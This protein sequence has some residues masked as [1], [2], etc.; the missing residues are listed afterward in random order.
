ML[1]VEPFF[2][3]FS[4]R[5][6]LKYC[7]KTV[8]YGILFYIYLCNQTYTVSL[9]SIFITV[10]ILLKPILTSVNLHIGRVADPDEVV[11]MLLKLSV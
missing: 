5:L 7:G 1:S 8:T 6:E 4:H 9:F 10:R 11:L 3:D 2:T